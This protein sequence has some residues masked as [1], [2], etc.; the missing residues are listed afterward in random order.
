M[1]C[2]LLGGALDRICPPSSVRELAEVIGAEK[3][4]VIEGLGHMAQLEAPDEVAALVSGFI[5]RNGHLASFSRV[6]K[7]NVA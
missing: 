7:A 3:V 4:T 2:E 6:A 1:P 5:V